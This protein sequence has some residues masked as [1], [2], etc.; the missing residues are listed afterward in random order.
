MNLAVVANPV[1]HYKERGFL[2]STVVSI[3]TP[4]DGAVVRY[5]L[6]GTRP[7]E[8]SPIYVSPLHLKETTEVRALAVKDS[9]LPSYVESVTFTRIPYRV[10]VTY[11][12]PYSH[13]YTAG[14]N[15]GLFDGVRGAL[16]AWGA[17]QGF[18]AVD[19]DAVIDL[20]ELREVNR[21]AATCLQSWKSWIWLPKSV[22]FSV[23]EDG[24]TFRSMGQLTHDV[25][26]EKDGS[27]TRDFVQEIGGENIRYIKLS[28]ENVRTCPDWHPGTGGKAWIFIDEVVIE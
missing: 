16:N 6:D 18:H 25:P 2:D 1:F 9:F 20:G 21:I 4:T 7:T 3:S 15:N 17:W 19:L 26:L 13:L 22:T 23:S 10:S 24:E 28:A 27:F 12:Q 14:G 8:R 11:N 5:T